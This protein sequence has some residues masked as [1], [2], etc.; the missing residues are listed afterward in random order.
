MPR[1]FRRTKLAQRL[2]FNLPDSLTGYVKFLTDLFASGDTSKPANEGH[3]KTGQRKQAGRELLYPVMVGEGNKEFA[4]VGG[5]EL[6]CEDLSGGYGNAGMRP[7]RRLSGRKGRDGWR[8]E[9]PSRLVWQAFLARKALNPGSARAAPSHSKE[10]RFR[11]CFDHCA[12][13]VLVRQ[14]RGP[15]LRIWP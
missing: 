9:I 6:N 15:H 13:A 2:G 7:E 12:G 10:P 8:S 3:L 5:V 11:F 1:A 14:L 4:M